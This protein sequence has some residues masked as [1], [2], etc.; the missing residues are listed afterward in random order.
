MKTDR[1]IAII[2]MLTEKKK[3]QAGELAELFGVSTRTIYRDIDAI[4]LAGIPV[5]SYPGAGGGIGIEENYKLDKYLLSQNDLS[6]II[7]ALTSILDIYRDERLVNALAKMRSLVTSTQNNEVAANPSQVIIDLTPWGG[8]RY[9]ERVK[10]IQEAIEQGRLLQLRYID[11]KAVS[12][13]RIVEPYILIMKL[14]TWY[15][16]AWCRM[17]EG[18]RLFK[19]GRMEGCAM[20]DERFAKRDNDAAARLWEK[21]WEMGNANAIEIV[22]RVAPAYRMGLTEWCGQENMTLQ[23][24]GYAIARLR[25]PE[26]E[27]VY[28]FLLGFGA[29]VEVLEPQHLREII[30]K[31]AE[32]TSLMYLNS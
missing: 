26:D 29:G 23:E 14:H 17:R 25:Y 20:L 32:E 10:T 11:S 24:D 7:S 15:L 12:T 30:R 28:S 8:A 6:G 2:M 31:R 21:N 18:F 22:L 3:V 27:W 19:L 5:I 16:Y 4:N 9:S 13:L 1:L